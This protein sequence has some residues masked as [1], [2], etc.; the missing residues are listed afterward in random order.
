[1]HQACC[2]V[3]ERASSHACRGAQSRQP[4]IDDRFSSQVTRVMSVTPGARQVRSSKRLHLALARFRAVPTPRDAR[5][6]LV[7]QIGRAVAAGFAA[8]DRWRDRFERRSIWRSRRWPFL[9]PIGAP[10]RDLDQ[11]A[12]V[13]R[14]HDGKDENAPRPP[15]S[16]GVAAPARGTRPCS[17]RN[18]SKLNRVLYLLSAPRNFDWPT[19][20]CVFMILA[21]ICPTLARLALIGT[22][23]R[24]LEM[25]PLGRIASQEKFF[26]GLRRLLGGGGKLRL[27]RA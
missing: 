24:T 19:N 14:H 1:M 11:T 15:R 27:S 17:A 6:A 23:P 3:F 13:L 18:S 22:M 7:E 8:T 16:S 25:K 12:N 20:S 10:P 21:I 5:L 9:A 26:K 4:R 2:S